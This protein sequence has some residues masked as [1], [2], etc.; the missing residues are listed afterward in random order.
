MVIPS[1]AQAHPLL[2]PSSRVPFVDIKNNGILTNHGVQL[3]QGLVQF[4]NGMN[5]LTP[6]SV[7]GT[8]ILT[9]TPNPVFPF[10]EKYV[11]FEVYT[12]VA[13]ATSTSL[14]TATIV[15]EVGALDTLRVYK[16]NGATQANSGDIV[17]GSLYFLIYNDGLD[18]GNGGFVLK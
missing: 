1:E 10:I 13:V 4:I 14:V 3:L 15:P 11:D 17:S 18:G 8:N 7:S 2:A 12:F 9:L 6:C 16:D 5:R